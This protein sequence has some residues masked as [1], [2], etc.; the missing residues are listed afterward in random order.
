MVYPLM[1][2]VNY[3]C[4]P[5]VIRL[6]IFFCLYLYAGIVEKPLE[7]TAMVYTNSI[8]DVKITGID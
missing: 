4:L 1:T 6:R 8:K 2:Y 5:K 7:F 3:K